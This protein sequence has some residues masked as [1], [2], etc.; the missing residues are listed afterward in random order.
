VTSVPLD[1]TVMSVKTGDLQ[2]NF[3][4]LGLKDG[5]SGRDKFRIGIL[6]LI[7]KAYLLAV[8]F[9]A[10]LAFAVYILET[11]G[12]VRGNSPAVGWIISTS[13]LI[14]VLCRLIVLSLIHVTSFPAVIPRYLAPAYPLILIFISVALI[15]NLRLT[16][17]WS[18]KTR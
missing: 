5:L 2:L 18:Q 10:V 3:D 4:F 13:M 17:S 11:F 12:I 15:N 16:H 14:A 1:G 7:G 6:G 9:L 8:P